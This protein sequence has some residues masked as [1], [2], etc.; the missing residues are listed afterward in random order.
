MS[1]ALGPPVYPADLVSRRFKGESGIRLSFGKLLVNLLQVVKRTNT[2]LIT[3][4]N[5]VVGRPWVFGSWVRSPS[6]TIINF[7]DFP[8]VE[9][10][11]YSLVSPG[12]ETAWIL[13]G[14]PVYPA[15]LLSRRF[16]REE[17]CKA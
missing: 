17:C 2:P 8:H 13:K 6:S 3:L 7:S 15:D 9:L 4:T 1:D 16:R 12:N 10:E 14:P 5:G 11:K